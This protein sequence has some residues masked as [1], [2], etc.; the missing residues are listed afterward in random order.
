MYEKHALLTFHS[1]TQQMQWLLFS[2]TVVATSRWQAHYFSEWL[3]FT[4]SSLSSTEPM[5]GKDTTILLHDHHRDT[6]NS[7]QYT[8]CMHARKAEFYCLCKGR[9]VVWSLLFC[10]MDSTSLQQNAGWCTRS[11]A[12]IILWSSKSAQC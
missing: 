8:F 2:Q 6:Q 9:A 7:V 1:C 3:L 5:T 12:R 10:I 4:S 11:T